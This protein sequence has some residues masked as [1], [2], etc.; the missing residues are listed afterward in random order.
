MGLELVLWVYI[1]QHVEERSFSPVKVAREQNAFD[2]HQS[3][4]RPVGL[5]DTTG[6]VMNGK[7]KLEQLKP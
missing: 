3:G 5:E 6:G 7:G 4:A 1:C 2:G